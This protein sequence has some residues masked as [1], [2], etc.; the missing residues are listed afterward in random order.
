MSKKPINKKTIPTC[1]RVSVKNIFK[2][3]YFYRHILF[4][5][6]QTNQLDKIP[7]RVQIHS[8]WKKCANVKDVLDVIKESVSKKL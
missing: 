2:V 1:Y 8:I 7:Q 6:K 4:Y 5:L 3:K